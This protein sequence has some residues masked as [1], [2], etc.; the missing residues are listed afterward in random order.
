MNRW[1][2]L[3]LLLIVFGGWKCAARREVQRPPGVLVQEQPVQIDSHGAAGFRHGDFDITPLA[4]FTLRARVLSRT[5][6]RFDAGAALSPLDL[7]LGWGRMSDTDV[8]RQ[9]DIDQSARFY[10]YRWDAEGPVIPPAEIARSSANMH[11]VPADADIEAALGRVR[12]GDIVRIE[13]ELIQALRDDGWRWR[14]SM[15]RDDT[16]AG[17]CE[18]VWVTSIVIEPR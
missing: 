1:L 8:I 17:A 11:L 7:A 5:D 10:S 14:S 18:L 2:L 12:R 3:A 9:L 15:T 13:G 6:Y 4:A 16:G